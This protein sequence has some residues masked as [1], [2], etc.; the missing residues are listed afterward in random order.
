M[1]FFRTPLTLISGPVD[2]QLERDDLL[3][4][5][6]KD[7]N[8]VKQN[9]NRLLNLVNQMIDLSL[10]DS[11]QLSLKVSTG[12]LSVL[13]NQIVEAFQYKS[14]ERGISIKANIDKINRVNYNNRLYC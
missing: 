6:K 4:K 8:L 13:L 14:N 5:D 11:G 12:N 3:E 2:K 1:N 9:A 10:V 7:L